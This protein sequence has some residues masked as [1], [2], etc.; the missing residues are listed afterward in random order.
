MSDLETTHAVRVTINGEPEERVVQARQLLVHFLRE[1]MEMKGT[2]IGC[3]TGNCGA[4]TVLLD[5]QPV[6]SC[7]MLAPQADG[8]DIQTV[9][10]LSE[11]GG[12]LSDLQ[13]AFHERHALQCGWCTSGML[14]QSKA[15]LERDPNPSVD[16][17]RRSLKGNICR[18]TGY[19]NIVRAIQ[20]AAGQTVD[21]GGVPE[22][23]NA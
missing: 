19:V 5:G 21:A 22:E 17:I 7:M 9:E 20:Q 23:A 14:L 4:C 6:K 11:P 15:L 1:T 3:D 2:H 10:S 12:E 8:C 16:T 18:C 13:K